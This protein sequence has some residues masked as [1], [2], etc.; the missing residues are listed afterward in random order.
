MVKWSGLVVV[1][2]GSV[3]VV[4]DRKEKRRSENKEVNKE[5]YGTVRR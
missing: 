5:V 2:N 3:N 1:E 4:E